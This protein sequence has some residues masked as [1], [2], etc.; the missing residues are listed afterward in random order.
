M[1][2]LHISYSDSI[3]GGSAR[4]A[5]R[6]HT[7]LRSQHV[8]SKMLV[9]YKKTSDDD[10]AFL[11]GSLKKELINRFVGEIGDKTGLQYFTYFLSF[12]M[13]FHPWYKQADIIQLYN[14]HG[15]YFNPFV[16]K[17][18]DNKKPIVWRLSDMWPFTGHCTYSYKCDKW[19]TG[20]KSCDD[21]KLQWSIPYSTSRLLWSVKKYIYAI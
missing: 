20:C 15:N 2:V 6:I 21:I 17:F 7:S 18:I 14:I 3:G 8:N 11:T 19:K 12:S 1:N 4:S 9:G 16:L 5:Y 10:V 13:L